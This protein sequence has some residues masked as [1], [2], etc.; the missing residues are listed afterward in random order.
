MVEIATAALT[1]AESAVAEKTV[2]GTV[3]T[4]ETMAKEVVGSSLKE[5]PKEIVKDTLDSLPKEINKASIENCI[6][7]IKGIVQDEISKLSN[8]IVPAEK[9]I[10][11][12]KEKKGGSY[13]DVKVDGE[14]GKKE[15]HHMPADSVSKLERNDGPAIKMD[16][17]D[18]QKTASFGNSKEARDYRTRQK[19]LIDSGRFGEALQMDIDDIREKFG[20]KYDEHI[21]EMREYVDQLEREGKI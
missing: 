5:L 20:D 14:G 15:V 10:A 1:L 11:D 9:E 16:K 18:H 13:K 3:K 7:D 21:S 2:E 6:E 4:I 17:E 19:E 12:I 8:E